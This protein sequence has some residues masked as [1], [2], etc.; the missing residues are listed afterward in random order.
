MDA[1]EPSRQ[2][3]R[4]IRL[5]D[6]RVAKLLDSLDA[7][8][9]PS[10][11]ERRQPRF[12][13]R[14][15]TL[16]VHMNQPGFAAPVSYLVVG[17]NISDKGL[18]FLHGG[19][20]HVS[21]RCLVQ[22]VTSYG[23]WNEMAATVVRCRYVEGKV[24]EVAVQF[25][26]EINPAVFCSEAVENRV[27]LVDDD[28]AVARLGTL[29]L[30]QLNAKVTVAENGEQALEQLQKAV[31]DLILMDMEMPGKDGFETVREM[32]SRGFTGMIAAATGLTQPGDRE[33][34]LA[35][36]CDRYVP[37]PYTRDDLALLLES[38]RQEPLY[39]TYHDDPAMKELVGVFVAELPAKLRAIEEALVRRDVLRLQY[40]CRGVKSEGAGYGFAPITE[41]ATKI[42]SELVRGVGL[43]DLQKEINTLVRLCMQARA[44]VRAPRVPQPQ[45]PPPETPPSTP[46]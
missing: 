27:L 36:G 17:R 32:R 18:A 26:E 4:T 14:V 41:A 24:H 28:V 6:E 8:S 40:L 46:P 23:T 1:Q 3:V 16:V 34:C 12:R 43:V 15:K 10:G 30:Q 2:L 29:Y 37:K 22:L 9:P 11:T 44:A 20:V 25:D 35:A 45:S 38:L 7:G 5:D 19:Y 31:F 33:K 13:Y 21:T 42:E 39:S